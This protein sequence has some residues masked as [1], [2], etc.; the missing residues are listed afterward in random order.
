MNESRDIE[1]WLTS[2]LE[3]PWSSEKVSSLLTKEIL[4]F[5]LSKFTKIDTI[6]RIKVLFS[7]LFLKKKQFG[8]LE[9]NINMLL[10]IADE[11][12]DEW[13]KVLGQLLM[14]IGQEKISTDIDLE[15]FK[16]NIK[17]INDELEKRTT[18]NFYPLENMYLNRN[19]VPTPT[20][21]LIVHNHF[22]LKKPC[23]EL[24]VFTKKSVN[25]TPSLS[26]SKS[27]L[28]NTPPSS[29]ISDE[30]QQDESSN[31]NNVGEYDMYKNGDHLHPLTQ[32]Y[33]HLHQSSDSSPNLKSDKLMMK[34]SAS[35]TPTLRKSNLFIPK[36][37]HIDISGSSGGLSPSLSGSSS[38]LYNS[39]GHHHQRNDLNSS[40]SAEKRGI[41]K[42]SKM[43]FI[44]LDQVR[45]SQTSLQQKKRRQSIEPS[46]S[47]QNLSSSISNITTIPETSPSN[48]GNEEDQQ[49][50]QQSSS[51][52]LTTTT[53]TTTTTSSTTPNK[54][55]KSSDDSTTVEK[56]EKKPKKDKAEKDKDKDKDKEKEKKVKQ[57][58]GPRSK[59]AAKVADSIT[60]GSTTSPTGTFS[61][62]DSPI[63][64]SPI[65][66]KS[67]AEDLS[68]LSTLLN[69]VDQQE[70]NQQ[71]PQQ[72]Q[73]H[74]QSQQ[75]QQQQQHQQ[76]P[77]MD[78]QKPLEP[79]YLLHRTTSPTINSHQGPPQPM[80]NLPYHLQHQ[81]QPIQQQ[82]QHYQQP[83]QQQPPPQ[84]QQQQQP[85]ST[86]T[87]ESFFE[88]ANQL[89]PLSRCIIEQFII[90]NTNNPT[91]H[92][93]NVK[94]IP[95]SIDIRSNADGEP[96]E[97]T[98]IFEA[99]YE[100]GVWKKIK[101]KR[102]IR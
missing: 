71:P 93:G 23:S 77:P 38:G 86:I 46:N 90:G 56:K 69:A 74:Q 97:E 79:Q 34:N 27:N 82:Q 3:E 12:E 78:Y 54:R 17:I 43:H 13:L 4:Q 51:S 70:Q 84:Q 87:L 26:G 15:S 88:S 29:S 24:P 73:Q 101:R 68:G 2:K 19:L 30:H 96:V 40:S 100:T 37:H 98:V 102:K 32:Q 10:A 14:N 80:I 61:G 35:G 57:T 48:N 91:P 33:N 65:L 72:H 66:N 39:H 31:N 67:M 62:G 47:D 60:P 36:S 81:Q 22:K 6:V 41:Q 21:S 75:Q 89:T 52:S 92:E 25:L 7:F 42:K 50:Q 59:K 18:L 20:E 45:E 5:F 8:E 28:L 53:T 95:L 99:N 83:I 9:S 64:S 49:Q 76:Y 94:Q 1:G 85:N 11:E 44:D 58:R 55:K 16:S 63:L